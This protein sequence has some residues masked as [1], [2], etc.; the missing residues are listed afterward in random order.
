MSDITNI[1]IFGA[2]GDLTRRK[3]IPAL[4]NLYVKNRMPSQFR[5]IGY[6]RRDWSDDHFRDVA[7]DGVKAFSG[8]SYDAD[9]WSEFVR[10]ICYVQ[11]N[12]DQSGDFVALKQYLDEHG[13]GNNLYYFAT[14]P[15]F[16]APV[17]HA[18]AVH[19][20]N[21]ENG[22]WRRVVIEKP[23]GHDLQ[24]A[25]NLT[26][27]LHKVFDESQLYRID[28]YLGKET[29]QNILFFRF[30]N[31]IIEPLWNRN[32]ISNVQITV[33]ESVD[34]G[35]RAGYYDTSGVLRDMFQN[36]L[37]QLLSLVA[38][39]P[40]T[41]FNATDLRNEKAKV[42]RAIR[43][44]DLA[45][46][47]RGQYEG[48]TD[49]DRVQPNTQTPTY[50]A[51]KLYV[52]N[53]RWQGVPFYLRSGKALIKKSSEINVV[54]KRPPHRMF[55]M[56]QEGSIPRNVLSLCIQPDEGIHLKMEAKVPDS[57][58][59]TR[60]VNLEF[61]YADSFEE[62]I[63]PDAYERLLHDALNGDAALYSRSDSIEISW[64]IID[65]IIQGWE[66]DP[67]APPMQTYPVGSWGPVT[68]D[69]LLIRDDHHW[70]HDC[71]MHE[72]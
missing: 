30:T 57:Q 47:V 67:A 32:Y 54:F 50:A 18:L 70:R 3:L 45:D 27:E 14:A 20:L 35:D 53:W 59:E 2:T 43:P 13:A 65:P 60:S 21:V 33:A 4:Y 28:H 15:D 17:A 8:T 52:D 58:H 37:L 40:P 66:H 29:A 48:Y 38:M 31:T 10:S 22:G 34:V 63:I 1:I 12:L 72:S 56:L 64:E 26:Q 5:I 49:L 55:D 42:L 71:G 7:E 44:I 41:S 23:F 61:H 36:H 24:S 51:L 11:G 46:T 19:G 62:I 69:E 6:A 68:A 9:T 25:R 16:F 39:E